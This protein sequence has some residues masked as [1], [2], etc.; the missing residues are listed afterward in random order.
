MARIKLH[1][2]NRFVSLIAIAIVLMPTACTARKKKHPDISVSPETSP[3]SA[4]DSVSYGA[5][6]RASG[7]RD[8]I[9]KLQI[10][11]V[12]SFLDS[13]PSDMLSHQVMMFDSKSLQKA[14]FEEPRIIVHTSDA[15]FVAAFNGG[16]G[17]SR[18]DRSVEFIEFN[19][20]TYQFD[21][22]EIEFPNDESGEVKFS[23]TNPARCLGCHSN[24]ARPNWEPY[25]SWPGAFGSEDDGIIR[26][27]QEESKLREFLNGYGGKLRY[28]KLKNL[29]KRFTLTAGRTPSRLEVGKSLNM[30]TTRPNL[31]FLILLSNL[32]M[33][34]IANEIRS[35]PN[36]QSDKYFIASLISGCL[37]KLSE[38]GLVVRDDAYQKLKGIEPRLEQF[39]TADP[40]SLKPELVFAGA[41]GHLKYVN[42]KLMLGY[43]I[44]FSSWSMNFFGDQTKELGIF[45]KGFFNDASTDSIQGL[46][47][48]KLS[49]LDPDFASLAGTCGKGPNTAELDLGVLVSG[50]PLCAPD[51]KDFIVAGGATKPGET[52]QFCSILH[53]KWLEA[54]R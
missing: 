30:L 6:S 22:F 46:V 21:F 3:N 37:L 50:M 26:D 15:K 7:L 43:Q 28:R 54:K 38:K 19:S 32:N 4:A 36:Y 27:A 45:L 20:S 34:R 16:S 53:N 39:K 14:S 47:A 18:E 8:L 5:G 17:S 11:S 35:L 23:E 41:A 13:L 48:E 29:D 9:S 33:L 1:T 25:F 12:D 31:S 24:P 10:K 49:G 40:N 52:P 51:L 44:N 2:K 42:D